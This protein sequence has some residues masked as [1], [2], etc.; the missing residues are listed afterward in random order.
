MEAI[1]SYDTAIPAVGIGTWTLRGEQ[2]AQ[3]VRDAIAMGY[4]H[5][6]T[7]AAYGNEE[8][9][10]EGVRA[11][12]VPRGELFITTKVQPGD[13]ADGDFQRSVEASLKRLR[14]DHVDLVLI[15]WPSPVLSVAETMEPLNDVRR[16]GLALH[17][18]VSN[19]TPRRLAEA[20]AHTE[21]PIIVNQCEYHPYL[22]QDDLIAVCEEKGTVLV[23]YCPLGRGRSFTE[24]A[25]VEIAARHGVTPAQVVLRWENQ[26]GAVVIPRSTKTERLRSNLDI[27]GFRLDAAEMAAISALG[28]TRH[29]RICNSS[30]IADWND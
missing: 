18:G 14:M 9:V 27:F 2:C 26:Q 17:I 25:I 3:V 19:F 6:D 4:R 11:S 21:F 1:R 8:R 10:G 7:A 22:N 28:R 15:H 29:E 30:L 20:W 16:R 23:A 5:V 12:G 24:P 13:L